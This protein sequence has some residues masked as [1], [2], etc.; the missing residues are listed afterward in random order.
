MNNKKI[1]LKRKEDPNKKPFL[2]LIEKRIVSLFTRD[3][4]V[5][6]L[7][8]NCEPK[9]SC[10][11]LCTPSCNKNQVCV[12]KTITTCGI[13]PSTY[14]MDNGQLQVT[15]TNYNT[16]NGY[17]KT[18]LIAG[19]TTGLVVL[20]LIAVTVAG[21]VY[22]K[23]RKL[24][25]NSIQEPF[26]STNMSSSIAPTTNESI[27]PIPPMIYLPPTTTTNINTITTMKPNT[28]NHHWSQVSLRS[29]YN[30]FIRKH[31]L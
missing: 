25:Q 21:F 26:A 1:I 11:K 10:P 23:R 31:I 9:E 20:A 14:C 15:A 2:T 7:V 22:Y 13:C 8:E 24:K 19:L 5:T 18:A 6:Q 4:N 17:R 27:I 29:I 16:D 3:L 28:K 30:S 12:Y